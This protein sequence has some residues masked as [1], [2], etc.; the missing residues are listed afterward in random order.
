[1]RKLSLALRLAMLVA[2]TTLPPIIFA[3]AVIYRGYQKDRDAATA[4][5]LETARSIRTLLDAE[6]QRM[7][8]SLQVLA[9]TDSLRTGDFNQF[10]QMASGFLEQYPPGGALLISDRSGR[11]LFST[12]SPDVSALP[13]RNNLAMVRQVFETGKPAYSNLFFGVSLN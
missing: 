9:L 12:V 11:Q 6:L 7:T 5:V 8:G 1:M 4:R 10:R 3:G 2:G 13:P